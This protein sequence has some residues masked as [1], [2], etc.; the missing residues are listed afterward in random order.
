LL[1]GTKPSF[2]LRAGRLDWM[3]PVIPTVGARALI[4]LS[5]ES[6]HLPLDTFGRVCAALEPL[7]SRSDTTA[8]H[9]RSSTAAASD[10]HWCC[11]NGEQWSPC[12]RSLPRLASDRCCYDLL[13]P[14]NWSD[15]FGPHNGCVWSPLPSLF[16]HDLASGL[17]PISVLG[18]CLVSWIFY[19]AS[20]VLLEVLIIRSSHRLC[21]SHVC[22]LLDYKN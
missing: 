10:P 6:G 2:L 3:R 5:A 4:G 15:M 1:L 22:N 13:L 16:L 14:S 19:C 18:L 8:W 12:V 21:P 11:R 7:W 17:V 20:R 9:V